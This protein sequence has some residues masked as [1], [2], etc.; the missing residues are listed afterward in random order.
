VGW[1]PKMM[2]SDFCFAVR[3]RASL[4]RGISGLVR[5]AAGDEHRETRGVDARGANNQDDPLLFFS[6][7]FS[8]YSSSTRWLSSL[9]EHSYLRDNSRLLPGERSRKEART[10]CHLLVLFVLLDTRNSHSGIHFQY[11]MFMPCLIKI[12]RASSTK[13]KLFCVLL[14]DFLRPPCSNCEY[15]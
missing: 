3:I 2:G 9:A 12:Y 11:L 10:G 14:S 8:T 7:F 13:I 15:V 5:T 6:L 4:Y 1:V